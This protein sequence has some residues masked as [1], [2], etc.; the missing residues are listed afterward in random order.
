MI[1]PGEI[2]FLDDGNEANAVHGCEL[3]YGFD[4]KTYE[5]GSPECGFRATIVPPAAEDSS[6]ESPDEP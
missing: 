4:D 6:T 1:A 3:R 2:E 5:I